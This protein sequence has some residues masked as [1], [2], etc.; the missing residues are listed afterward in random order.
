MVHNE[1]IPCYKCGYDLQGIAKD[2]PCPESGN[3]HR[4]EPEDLSQGKLMRLINANIA[5]KGLEPLP[6][7][8][9]R[10][11][12]WM[13]IGCVFVLA[14]LFLQV[15]VTFALIPIGVYRFLLFGLSLF[16]PTVVVGM[17][18]PNV[19]NSMPH[20][21]CHIRKW[22]PPTQWC[23]AIG[24]TLWL[25]FHVPTEFGTLGGNLKFFWPLLVL[26]CIAGI[27]VVGLAFWLHDFAL[28]M[29]LHSAANKCNI[30]AVG[31]ATWGVLV[32]VLP[33]KHFAADGLSGE[34]GAIMWWALIL[35][36][37]LPW[38]WILQLFARALYEFSSD[39]NWSMKYEE[40]RKGRRDRIRKKREEYEKERGW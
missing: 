12:Y 8:R 30:V 6:D 5:V 23:W 4:N 18:P 22:I 1:P 26:H 11:T 38:F 34:Q 21:Y 31:F 3:T 28:R 33:W 13:Q 16:W 2:T 24:Y 10:T 35:G 9:Y 37:M 17:M 25:V 36:L 19:D 27:G 15:L 7:I 29:D 20:M 14:L 32:S 39:S 40:G